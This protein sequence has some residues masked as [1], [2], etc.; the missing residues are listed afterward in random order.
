[1]DF[2]TRAPD[3]APV[4]ISTKLDFGT[5][6]AR[7]PCGKRF[8]KRGKLDCTKAERK[9]RSCWWGDVPGSVNSS[10]ARLEGNYGRPL[11]ADPDK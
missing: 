3:N 2:V 8:V 7:V 10:D 1:M 9:V 11:F 4:Y 5:A 6:F